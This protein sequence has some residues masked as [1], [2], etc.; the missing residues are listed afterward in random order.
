MS[1]EQPQHPDYRRA[2]CRFVEASR[3][4]GSVR[5]DL[6]E[7]HVAKGVGPKRV[8]RGSGRLYRGARSPV[9]ARPLPV[10]GLG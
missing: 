6:R 4:V 3:K 2:R 9:S 8:R 5:R 10:R 1:E 7:D